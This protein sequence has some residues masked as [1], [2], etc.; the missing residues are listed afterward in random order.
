[1]ALINREIVESGNC[2]NRGIMDYGIAESFR[3]LDS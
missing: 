3:I 2:G 1:M